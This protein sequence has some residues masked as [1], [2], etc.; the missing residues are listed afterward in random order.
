M[1]RLSSNPSDARRQAG[2]DKQLV[3][4][5]LQDLTRPDGENCS[6]FGPISKLTGLSRKRV[7]FLCRLLTR[8]G[9]AE[10]HK[11]LWTESGEPAG[12]GYC[13]SRKGARQ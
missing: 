9:M 7:R 8:Q 11:G 3:L 5:A 13:V 2:S 10:F 12:A 4:N 1:D 6:S